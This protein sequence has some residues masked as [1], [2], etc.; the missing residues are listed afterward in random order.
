MPTLKKFAKFSSAETSMPDLW[1]V[2]ASNVHSAGFLLII[3]F[4]SPHLTSLFARVS[5]FKRD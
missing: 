4:V 5:D 1:M 3:G 2:L